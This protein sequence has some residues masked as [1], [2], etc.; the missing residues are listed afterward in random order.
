MYTVYLPISTARPVVIV[1]T[2]YCFY[3]SVSCLLVLYQYS[4][5]KQTASN[6]Y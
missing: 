3:L 6:S 5:T 1:F 2:H 4:H